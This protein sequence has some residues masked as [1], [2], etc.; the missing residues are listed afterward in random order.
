MY[1]IGIGSYNFDIMRNPPLILLV[2]DDPQIQEIYSMKLSASG[3]KII[4]ARNGE[5]GVKI[6]KQE[7]P[8]LILLD[9][10]MPVMDGARALVELREDPET[11]N[12]P[13]LILTSLEDRPEDIKFAKEAGAVDFMR[14]DIDFNDLL[15][16]IKSA[17]K[18]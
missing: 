3:Y 5:E 8:D 2:D 13:V 18:V 14:K 7:R 11:K 12:I 9:I 15:A 4:Q 17:I 16:K 10:L 1:F 6:A